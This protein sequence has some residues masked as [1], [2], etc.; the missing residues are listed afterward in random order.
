MRR[1]PTRKRQH[2][3]ERLEQRMLFAAFPVTTT[4]DSGAGSLRQAI[5]DA[6]ANTGN[7]TITFAISTGAQT[8]SPATP[9]PALTDAA[10]ATIA[11][12]TQPGF[13]VGTPVITIDGG[14]AGTGADG[15]TLSG[16]NNAVIGLIIQDFDDSQIAIDGAGSD[17]ILGNVI[18]DSATGVGILVDAPNV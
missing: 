18:Q 11:G 12:S 13:V 2:G 9:L 14:S 8:I 1:M 15:L 7:D 6:N 16:G 3:L 10:G 5:L 17:I 4:A